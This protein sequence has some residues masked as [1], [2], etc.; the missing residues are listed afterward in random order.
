M[1]AFAEIID[2]CNDLPFDQHGKNA[3]AIEFLKSTTSN[4]G[5]TSFDISKTIPSDIYARGIRL[6]QITLKQYGPAKTT[7]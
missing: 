7:P 3:T 4:D 1:L 6:A 5:K 2:F